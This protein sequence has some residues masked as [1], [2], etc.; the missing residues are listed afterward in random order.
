MPFEK[1]Y[2]QSPIEYGRNFPYSPPVFM[3]SIILDFNFSYSSFEY[4]LFKIRYFFF[5]SP[6]QPKQYSYSSQ[7]SK[8]CEYLALDQEEFINSYP[9][10]TQLL[11]PAISTCQEPN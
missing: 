3:S 9:P 1:L 2:P 4:C 7:I 8:Y 6:M 10:C 11:F 5:F